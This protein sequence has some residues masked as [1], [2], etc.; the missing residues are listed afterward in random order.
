M[1]KAKTP[2]LELT[3]KERACLRAYKI[4]RSAILE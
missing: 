1:E 2:R 4:K 3:D